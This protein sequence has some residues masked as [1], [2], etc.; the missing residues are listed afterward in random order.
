MQRAYLLNTAGT[1]CR[2]SESNMDDVVCGLDEAGRGPLAGPVTAGAVILP[3]D[4]PMEILNDSKKLSARKRE[5]AE[6]IIKEQAC[7]GVGIVDHETIDRINILQASLYAMK[8]AYEMMMLRLP[9]WASAHNIEY[10]G[11]TAIAD[12][13]FCPD[14]SC[15]C[16]CEP[17]ADGTYQPVMA[18]SI[19]AK[20]CRD[21][22]MIEM[23]KKY[24]QYGYARHKGYPTAEHMRICREIGPSPIQRLTFKY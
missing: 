11:I 8:L 22:I 18:A 1:P 14:I 19:I 23:D 16:R 12:G 3:H 10:S 5:Y 17:K 13:T 15:P 24:P 21:A 4:F 20:T 9:D 7:W 6:K 2:D